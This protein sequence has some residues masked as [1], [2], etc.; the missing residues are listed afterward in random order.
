[1]ALALVLVV[2]VVHIGQA[3]H[4]TELVAHGAYALKQRGVFI[5][6]EQLGGAGIQ[7]ESLAVEARTGHQVTR[8]VRP[9]QAAIMTVHMRTHAGNDEKHHVHNAVVVGVILAVVHLAVRQVQGAAKD[10]D[11]I[12]IGLSGLVGTHLDGTHHVKL[13]VEQTHGVVVVVVAHTARVVAQ[14]V[15]DVVGIRQRLQVAL[16]GHVVVIGLCVAARERHIAQLNENHK[17]LELRVVETLDA[18]CLRLHLSTQRLALCH[19]GAVGE[20]R[21]DGGK[22]ITL[23]SAALSHIVR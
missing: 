7:V 9:Q 23:G 18:A 11:A 14:Q 16:V 15:G 6:V 20:S 10:G 8:H 17:S 22:E 19:H 5:I 1:M 12:G 21:L 13:G 2:G 3:E 4:M